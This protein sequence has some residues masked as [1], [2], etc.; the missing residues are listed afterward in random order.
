MPTFRAAITEAG[1]IVGI[2]TRTD[3]LKNLVPEPMIPGRLNLTARLE[4]A[5]PADR[6]AG[7]PIRPR[8][9]R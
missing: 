5:L 8:S 9:S 6:L 2:V 1:D 3:L 4:T 7:P